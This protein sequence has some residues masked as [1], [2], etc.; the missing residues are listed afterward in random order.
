M[1]VRTNYCSCRGKSVASS[2]SSPHTSVASSTSSPH[3]SAGSQISERNT[4]SSRSIRRSQANCL[5]FLTG[6]GLPG[7]INRTKPHLLHRIVLYVYSARQQ[8]P[9]TATPWP[10]QHRRVTCWCPAVRAKPGPGFFSITTGNCNRESIVTQ[11][12]H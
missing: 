9:H 7:Q 4:S 10:Q 1:K 12:K 2:T 6:A 3:T 11:T 8:L 5:F